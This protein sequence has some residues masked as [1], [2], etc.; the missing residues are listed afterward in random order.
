VLGDGDVRRDRDGGHHGDGD[1]SERATYGTYEPNG[2]AI[3][4]SS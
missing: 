2:A 4:R 1:L 3:V